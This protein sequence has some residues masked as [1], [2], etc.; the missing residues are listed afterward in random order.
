MEEDNI[1]PNFKF[2]NP[3][4][5]NTDRT[6]DIEFLVIN[7]GSI[8]DLDYNDPGYINGIFNRI[9]IQSIKCNPNDFLIKMGE[10]LENDKYGD[11]YS[12]VKKVIVHDEPNYIYEIF[13][14]DIS[15]INKLKPEM[16]NG[17]GTLLNI[18]ENHIFGN[19]ILLKTHVPVDNF[20]KL[21]LVEVSKKDINNILNSRVNTNV[22]IYEDGEFREEKFAG[23]IHVHAKRIFNDQF[24]H[25]KEIPFLLHNLNIFYTFDSY[26]NEFM[27][28]L[29]KGKI[30]LAIFFTMNTEKLRGNISRDEL[31]KIIYLSKKLETFTVDNELV[32]DEKDDFNRTIIK[33]KYRILEYVY[34]SNK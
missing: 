33:N 16:F 12:Q 4:D 22:I 15:D 26:G 17:L 19:C 8:E 23:D 27:P 1:D 11:D 5:I 32:K 7:P 18:E 25:E 13:F 2:I 3:K 14:L 24:Y 20:K 34:N 29:V 31:D 28:N 21:D 6:D 9:N 30:E 10:Y